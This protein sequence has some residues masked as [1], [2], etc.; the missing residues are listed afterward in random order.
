VNNV[1]GRCRARASGPPKAGQSAAALVRLRN[2]PCLRGE[3]R[4]LRISK[5]VDP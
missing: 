5:S 2:P 3:L 4:V 1:Q